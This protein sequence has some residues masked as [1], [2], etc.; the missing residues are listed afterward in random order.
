[1]HTTSLGL[2]STI[3]VGLTYHLGKVVA[4]WNHQCF[5]DFNGDSRTRLHE[6]LQQRSTIRKLFLLVNTMSMQNRGKGHTFESCAS[7]LPYLGELGV[8]DVHLR[9]N[10]E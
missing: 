5:H 6:E 2:L 3:L 9:M 4:E 8:S 1:M 7:R 10:A